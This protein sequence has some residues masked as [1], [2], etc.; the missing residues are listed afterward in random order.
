VTTK[1]EDENFERR[2][3]DPVGGHIAEEG[4]V[5][6]LKEEA[7]AAEQMRKDWEERQKNAQ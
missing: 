1:K 3:T 7:R 5:E 6:K 2:M 4:E